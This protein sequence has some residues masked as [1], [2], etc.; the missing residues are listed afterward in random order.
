VTRA[1]PLAVLAALALAGCFEELDLVPEVG[2]P[3][4]PSCVDEDSDPDTP[5]SFRD[6]ILAGVFA[7]GGDRACTACHTMSGATPIGVRA[8]DFSVSSYSSVLRGGLSSGEDIVLPG[9]PCQ[10]ILLQKVGE[11]P[12]F[13]ARM[14]LSGPPFLDER[15]RQLVADWI[16][17]GADDN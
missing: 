5:V 13:G 17:E 11:A 6:D 3:L 16:A 8:T 4:R 12:P 7:R 9:R 10:S 2:A 15:D 1:A 14:P